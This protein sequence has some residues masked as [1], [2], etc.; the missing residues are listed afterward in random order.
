M[1]SRTSL[2]KEPK[3]AIDHTIFWAPWKVVCPSTDEI[4]AMPPDPRSYQMVNNRRRP[5]FRSQKTT[6]ARLNISSRKYKCIHCIC[7]ADGDVIPNEANIPN[8]RT[9][10]GKYRVNCNTWSDVEKCRDWFNCRCRT[11]ML[12]PFRDQDVP[13]SEYQDALNNIPFFVKQHYP[14]FRWKEDGLDMSWTSMTAGNSRPPENQQVER[15]LVPG[16]TE[17]YYLEG[18]NQNPQTEWIT[19]LLPGLKDGYS[20]SWAMNGE[21]SFIKRSSVDSSVSSSSSGLENDSEGQ[22]PV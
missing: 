10:P 18:K 6:R 16:T 4:L 5:D 7:S 13:L 20:T 8:P 11:E 3:R 12:N 9:N 15:W 21:S 22:P 1:D 17:P 14:G 19:S 2:E